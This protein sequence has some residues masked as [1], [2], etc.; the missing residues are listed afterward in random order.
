MDGS[1]EKGLMV[2]HSPSHKL[3]LGSRSR[4]GIRHSDLCGDQ[5]LLSNLLSV[6][7]LCARIDNDADKVKSAIRFNWHYCGRRDTPKSRIIGGGA[8]LPLVRPERNPS[9]GW[10]TPV[11]PKVARAKR[12]SFRAIAVT[13][14]NDRA[15]DEKDRFPRFRTGCPIMQKKMG[16][17]TSLRHPPL[18]LPFML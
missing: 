2:E 16:E 14:A 13:A 8:A 17:K 10:F 18:N 15:I 12:T 5:L 7:V 11:Q 4:V 1:L 9:E 3:E 6:D